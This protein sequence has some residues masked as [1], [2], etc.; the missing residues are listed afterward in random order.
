MAGG[1]RMND[2]LTLVGRT[3]KPDGFT[4]T[5]EARR[6]VFCR[7][8]SIGQQEFYM[9]QTTD[10]QPELKLVLP[11]YLE[12]A[13]EQLCIYEGTWYRIIRTYRQGLELEL[14]VQRATSEEVEAWAE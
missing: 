10:L 7:Q 6:E 8:A 5:A 4:V 11:D 12:Y 14:V 13:D 3:Y 9:A 2:I 1:L